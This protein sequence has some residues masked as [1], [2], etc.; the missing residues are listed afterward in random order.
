ML[1]H[2]IGNSTVCSAPN[3]NQQE[4]N[5]WMAPQISFAVSYFRRWKLHTSLQWRHN[6][7]GGVSNHPLIAQLLVHAKVKE[8][9][10][11]PRHWPLCGEFTGDRWIPR[12]KSSNAEN[13][14]I[15]WRHHAQLAKYLFYKLHDKGSPQTGYQCHTIRGFTTSRKL[16]WG[17]RWM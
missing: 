5:I 14:S 11:A 9:I 16:V 3:P 12:T 8:N 7:R 1:S 13:A 4:R 2:L 17:A 10:K 15:W 6:E